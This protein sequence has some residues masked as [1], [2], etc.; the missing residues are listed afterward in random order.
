MVASA[1]FFAIYHPPLAW[2][3]VG[4]VGLFNAYLFKRTGRL[5]PC[6]A[7]HAIYNA[8]VTLSI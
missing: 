5:L 4:A 2:L 3:P 1:S 6:V 7:V 8:M